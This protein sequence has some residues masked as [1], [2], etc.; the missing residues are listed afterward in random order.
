MER[1]PKSG[2]IVKK[3]DDGTVDIQWSDGTVEECVPM[4]SPKPGYT[5]KI[6][7]DEDDKGPGAL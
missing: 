6:V 7:L 4:H 3:H 1:R 5:V 2:R